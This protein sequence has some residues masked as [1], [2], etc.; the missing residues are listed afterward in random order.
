M[1]RFT[2][3]S[4]DFVLP[5]PD[6]LFEFVRVLYSEFRMNTR[7][8]LDFWKDDVIPMGQLQCGLYF[9]FKS[10]PIRKIKKFIKNK[11]PDGSLKLEMSWPIPDLIRVD[12]TNKGL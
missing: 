1:I 7:S 6:L 9:S 11:A 8:T 10:D 5:R 3:R 12:I 4:D 2:F